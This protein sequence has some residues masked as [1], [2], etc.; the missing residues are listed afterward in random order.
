MVWVALGSKFSD[1]A[2]CLAASGKGY[3]KQDNREPKPPV[4][5]SFN[6]KSLPMTSAVTGEEAVSRT[7]HYKAQHANPKC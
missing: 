6:P 7:S 4:D 3:G 2:A 1:I 5:L